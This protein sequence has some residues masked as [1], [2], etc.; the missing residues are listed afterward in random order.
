[1]STEKMSWAFREVRTWPLWR[2]HRARAASAACLHLDVGP[3]IG[4]D[5]QLWWKC[6]RCRHAQ[7]WTSIKMGIRSERRHRSV[8]LLFSSQSMSHYH[9]A[10]HQ[11]VTAQWLFLLWFLSCQPNSAHPFFF[12]RHISEPLLPG[13]LTISSLSVLATLNLQGQYVL[14]L[15]QCKY[16]KSSEEKLTAV[17]LWWNNTWVWHADSSSHIYNYYLW[18]F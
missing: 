12:L 18:A 6:D 10:T 4:A 3:S 8:N 13:F 11:L 15:L 5:V 2:S 7:S 9:M 17:T 1:M 14:F 16:Y